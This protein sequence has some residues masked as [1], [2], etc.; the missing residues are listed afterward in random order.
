M[1]ALTL[2]AGMRADDALDLLAAALALVLFAW[3]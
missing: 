2:P 3:A 1:G